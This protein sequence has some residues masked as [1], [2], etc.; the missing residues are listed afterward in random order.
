MQDHQLPD[1][2]R[3]RLLEPSHEYLLAIQHLTPHTSQK[4]EMQFG[5]FLQDFGTVPS[6]ACAQL[7]FLNQPSVE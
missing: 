1:P 3:H 4:G 7:G 5:E 6:E 2:S